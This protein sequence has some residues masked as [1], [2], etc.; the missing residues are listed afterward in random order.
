MSTVY[1]GGRP[2]DL[3][4]LIF[5][6]EVHLDEMPGVLETVAT[7]LRV[8]GHVQT[9][10]HWQA[11]AIALEVVVAAPVTTDIPEAP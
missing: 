7:M 5:A 2:R 3:A 11:A 1:P 9:A 8:Q 10:D 6:S 4:S